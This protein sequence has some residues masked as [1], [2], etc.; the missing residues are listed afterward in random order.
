MKVFTLITIIYTDHDVAL[1]IIKQILLIISFIDKLNFRLMRA[2]DCLQH[3]NLNIR[4]K[5]KKQYI[6]SDILF[7]LFSDNNDLQKFFA[8]DEL[9]ALHIFLQKIFAQTFFANMM[10]LI[11]SLIKMNSKFKRCIIKEYKLNLN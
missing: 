5:F 2:S 4:H 6:I 9:N 8:D 7:K 11:T 3:F 10:H 1:K